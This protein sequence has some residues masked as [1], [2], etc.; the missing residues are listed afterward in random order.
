MYPPT[1]L[2]PLVPVVGVLLTVCMY[3]VQP[4]FGFVGTDRT[5]EGS[6]TQCD[7]IKSLLI[8]SMTQNT[9]I[10][11]QYEK[12]NLYGCYIFV[13]QWLYILVSCF[14]LLQSAHTWDA[15]RF[16]LAFH[17]KCAICLALTVVAMLM[18]QHFNLSLL[19]SI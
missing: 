8:N 11:L 13:L 3:C 18:H 4:A 1:R 5:T 9:Q 16:R 14:Y 17:L 12:Q 10:Q 19:S 6:A 2:G 15:I 7:V